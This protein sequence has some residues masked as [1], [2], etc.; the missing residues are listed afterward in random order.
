MDQTDV[1][2]ARADGY[3]AGRNDEPSRPPNEHGFLH[4]V[5]FKN[6]EEARA[7]DAYGK[8]YKEG[9]QDRKRHSS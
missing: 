4:D 7:D 5:A 3:A 6:L 2:R 9:E 8:A 1:D